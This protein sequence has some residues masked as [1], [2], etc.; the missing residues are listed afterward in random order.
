MID[1]S[2]QS[3]SVEKSEPTIQLT[4]AQRSQLQEAL[5]EAGKPSSQAGLM[6]RLKCPSRR[7]KAQKPSS[8]HS[9]ILTGIV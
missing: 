4:E 5:L 8:D 7:R 1:P 2:N 3:W 9:L 6:P